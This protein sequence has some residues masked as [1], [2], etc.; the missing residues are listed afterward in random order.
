[1]GLCHVSC[2]ILYIFWGLKKEVASS[3]FE[4][5]KCTSKKEGNTGDWKGLVNPVVE[6]AGVI[7]GQGST[8]G[9][10]GDPRQVDKWGCPCPRARATIGPVSQL[11]Q[12]LPE[13]NRQTPSS[14]PYCSGDEIMRIYTEYIIRQRKTRKAA[15]REKACSYCRLVGQCGLGG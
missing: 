5:S 4:E 13:T 12:V 14:F 10:T 6:G 1:L 11:Q 9:V 7:S 15:T 2:F 3:S 8:V